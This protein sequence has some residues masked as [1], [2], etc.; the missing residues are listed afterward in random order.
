MAEANAKYFKVNLILI[1]VSTRIGV[2]EKESISQECVVLIQKAVPRVTVWHHLAE[3]CDAKPNCNPRDI[4][5]DQYLT[6]MKDSYTLHIIFRMD[7]SG[8]YFKGGQISG[9]QGT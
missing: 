9:E 6:L 2:Q 7:E 4:F 5:F 1:N 8:S 3:P